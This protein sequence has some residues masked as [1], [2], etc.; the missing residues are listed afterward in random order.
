MQ[1][2]RDR[3]L[4]PGVSLFL[5]PGVTS[6]DL[7][8]SPSKTFP[9]PKE[10]LCPSPPPGPPGRAQLLECSIEYL[11]RLLSGTSPS[12]AYIFPSL[13]FGEV[14]RIIS[15]SEGSAVVEWRRVL[16]RE[17]RPGS[18]SPSLPIIHLG[19]SLPLS[20][21]NLGPREMT[22]AII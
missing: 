4:S 3:I 21:P 11:Q 16:G 8:I 12:S 2:S 14:F 1:A 17:R 19:K 13:A 22:F 20:K 6:T 15:M 7:A 18:C 10:N 5:F 9:S